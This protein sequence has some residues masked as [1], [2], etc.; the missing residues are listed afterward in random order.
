MGILNFLP[1]VW[2]ALLNGYLKKLLVYGACC[3]RNYEGEIKRMGD[4]LHI[5]EIGDI[6]VSPYVRNVTTLTYQELQ[7]TGLL[8]PITESKSFS[9]KLDDCDSVQAR[10][11]LLGPATEKAAYTVK[12]V[13]DQFIA[14]TLS[15]EPGITAGLGTDGTPLEINSVNVRTILLLV[16][17][18]LDD[19]KVPRGGRWIVLPPWMVEDMVLKD[20]SLS[21]PN[22]DVLKEGLVTR[23]YGFDIYMSHN[24]PNTT[25]TK[26]K[27]LAGIPW[28]ATFAEQLAKIEAIRLQG[29]FAD[30]VRGLYLYG[31]KVTHPEA[32]AMAICNEA[33]EA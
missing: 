33:A 23:A 6:T 24:V 12:D 8:L 28:A 25:G 22:V 31:A 20:S 4:R 30:A 5:V 15:A 3:N 16:A 32:L 21:T 27:I 18:K 10:A 9:F 17:R 7:D 19:A 13:M 14:A 2:S 11:D 26:Y 1:E 29:S